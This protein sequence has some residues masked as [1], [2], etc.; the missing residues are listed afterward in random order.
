MNIFGFHFFQTPSI[1]TTNLGY[2]PDLRVFVVRGQGQ[3]VVEDAQ[4]LTIRILNCTQ[5]AMDLSLFFDNTIAQ[6][7]E[8]LWIGVISKQLGKIEAHQIYD[9]QLELVPLTCGLKV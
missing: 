2:L 7:E 3:C 8:F 9:I 5:R 4:K 1:A 6:R